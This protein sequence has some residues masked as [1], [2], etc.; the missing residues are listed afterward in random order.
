M[1]TV[2]L[3]DLSGSLEEIG[4]KQFYFC[5]ILK[6][7]YIPASVKRISR[8]SFSGCYEL[9]D[10]WYEGTEEEWLSIDS[11]SSELDGANIHFNSESN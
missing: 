6:E 1:P 10:V 3:L 7:V 2:M 4:D 11:R 5:E 8:G 9:T